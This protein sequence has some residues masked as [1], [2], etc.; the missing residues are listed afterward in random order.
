MSGEEGGVA[1]EPEPTVDAEEIAAITLTVRELLDYANSGQLLRGF[2][3]YSATYLQRFRAESGLSDEEFAATFGQV[4]APPPEAR[5]ELA[6]ITE[7]DVLPDGRLGA[8]VT[9]SDGDAA[10]PPERFVFVRA[11]GRWLI[12]DIVAVG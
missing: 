3:L 8:L 11:D 6:A 12:D 10:P 4:P 5:A 1:A 7:V 2:G 9:Y